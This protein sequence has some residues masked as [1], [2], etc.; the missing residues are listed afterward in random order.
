MKFRIIS[1]THNYCEPLYRLHKSDTEQEEILLLAGDIDDNKNQRIREFLLDCSTRFRSVIYISGNHEY[2]GSNIIRNHEKLSNICSK[3]DNV[4]YLN[5]QSIQIDDV[6]IFGCTLWSELQPQDFAK[7]DMLNDYKNIRNGTIERPYD[8]KLTTY[9]THSMHLRSKD[10]IT[11]F[12]SETEGKKIVMTHHAPSLQSLDPR[13]ANDPSNC[14]YASNLE[15]LMCE[16]NPDIWVHGH[17]HYKNDYYVQNTR[18]ICNPK[19]Y[20]SF[21]DSEYTG[22][23]DVLIVEV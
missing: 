10:A 22:Y 17:I 1:D 16:Y 11:K 6:S 13:Y 3:Y 2:Y 19:G 9:D 18:V 23:E 12:L 4:Y 14:F 20:V 7:S 5:N 21:R 8:R 15:D